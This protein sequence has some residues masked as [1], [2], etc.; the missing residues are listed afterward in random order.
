MRSARATIARLLTPLAR[1]AA[2]RMPVRDPWE[3]FEYDVPLSAFGTGSHH[4]FAW[5][6]EGECAV[7]VTSVD[8]IQDWLLGCEYARDPALFNEDDYWQ[9]P[10]TFEQIRRGDCE[11][12]ALWAWRRLVEL[13]FDADLV[14]GSLMLESGEVDDRGGHVWV[15]LRRDGVPYLLESVAKTREQLL[16]PLSAVHHRYRPE[17]GVDRERRPYAFNGALAALRERERAPRRK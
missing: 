12:H 3:R 10:R 6:F 11:D 5:Y 1:F 2:R 17:F 13:G 7:A 8:E 14:S 16:Q 9:H 15:L 4:D